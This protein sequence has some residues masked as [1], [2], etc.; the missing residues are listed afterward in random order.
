[1]EKKPISQGCKRCVEWEG[2]V[3]IMTF[4][5]WVISTISL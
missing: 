4:N 3:L 2:N 5:G 1:M